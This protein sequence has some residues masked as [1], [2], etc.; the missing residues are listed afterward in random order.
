MRG[1]AASLRGRPPHCCSN[2]DAGARD[3]PMKES[4]V[5]QSSK[6]SAARVPHRAAGCRH[7]GQAAERSHQAQSAA[8]SDSERSRLR[9]VMGHIDRDDLP[10]AARRC[11]ARRRQRA[12]GGAL[13]DP[14]TASVAEIASACGFTKLGRVACDL[15]DRVWRVAFDHTP[16]YARTQEFS[17]Q[18]LPIL[19]SRLK[20]RALGSRPGRLRPIDINRRHKPATETEL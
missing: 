15:P 8:P 13:T 9:R 7:R 16:T 18:F 12:V 14:A 1:S 10:N 20:N 19:H 6:R 11:R 3:T 4:R 5:A 17:T 2:I